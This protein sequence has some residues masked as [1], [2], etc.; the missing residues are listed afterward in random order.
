MADEPLSNALR[1]LHDDQAPVITRAE[2]EAR[3]S[4]SAP[5]HRRRS[6]LV[7]A[8]AI[9]ILTAGALA[10]RAASKGPTDDVEA[11]PGGAEAWCAA[12]AAPA[13][14]GVIVGVFLVPEADPTVVDAVGAMLR[15]APEV[16]TVRYYDQD[17]AFADA[18]VL[19]A[20][21]PTVLRL[22]RREDVPTSFRVSLVD[23]ADGETLREQLEGR[24]GVQ[25]VE[26]VTTAPPAGATRPS[27][28]DDTGPVPPDRVVD[29]LGWLARGSPVELSDD[30]RRDLLVTAPHGVSDAIEAIDP[31]LDRSLA[32]EAPNDAGRGAA[33]AVLDA[34]E[35]RCD[36]VPRQAGI[37]PSTATTATTSPP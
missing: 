2:V 29:R 31:L 21:Q 35:D 34:A 11:G 1:R 27:P 4:P 15:S 25:Q 32:A 28:P 26:I 17:A 37:S 14:D 22:L 3:T 6:L 20:D 10:V 13:D 8:A 23:D 36:L 12:L 24:P 7:A 16:Q 30:A 5:G 18:Q 9:V 19:F 33:T